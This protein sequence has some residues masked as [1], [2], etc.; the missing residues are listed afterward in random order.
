MSEI[1][2]IFAGKAKSKGKAKE[3]DISFSKSA[4]SSKKEKKRGKKSSDTTGPALS[5]AEPTSAIGTKRKLPETVIDTSVLS[6]SKQKKSKGD[7][8]FKTALTRTEN[9]DDEKF[10]DS[11]GTGPR[12]RTEEG[13]AIYKEDELNIGLDGG[14]TPLCPFDCD[15]C[16]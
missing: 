4:E 14:D 8:R 6:E 2:D 12:K 9:S 15:C 3:L 11:R 16:F 7:K 10:K 13:Y 5:T 1:D